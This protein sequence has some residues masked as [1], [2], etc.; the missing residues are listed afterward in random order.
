MSGLTEAAERLAGA[1]GVAFPAAVLCCGR[2]ELELERAVGDADAQTWFDIASLTK[3]LG[4]SLLALAAWQAGRLDLDEEVLPGARLWQLLGHVS[5]LPACLPPLHAMTQG[6]LVRPSAATRQAVVAAARSAPR[7][8]AGQQAVYSDLGP[9]LVG[10]LLEQRVGRRLDEQLAALLEPLGVEVGFR[11]LDR[12]RHAV[13]AERTA[14]TRRESPAREPLRGVVHDDNARAMLGVAGHAG[15]FATASGVFRLAQALLDSYHDLG[16]PAQRALG[17]RGQALRRFFSIPEVPGL[18]TTWGLGW[19]HPDPH[20]GD[21]SP[22]RSSAGSLWPR[23]GVGHLGWT[24]CSLWLDLER[25]GAAVLLSNRVCVGTPAEAAAT[26]AA[27]RAL[28]PQLHDAIQ[29]AW[30]RG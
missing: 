4:T 20:P 17:L 2:G 9:I 24:G 12:A 29:R 28:R 21:G 6:W 13:P 15:L 16:T 10:D 5:G 25:R 11:P 1:V 18:L 7:G 14:P 3:A 19:D 27:V 26:Q 30:R 22:S 23:S 8:P